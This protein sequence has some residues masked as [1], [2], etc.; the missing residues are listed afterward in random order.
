M[1]KNNRARRAA[2]SRNRSRD[3]ARR[4]GDDTGR[5]SRWAPPPDGQPL[6]G[7]P[8]R[9]RHLLWQAAREQHHSDRKVRGQDTRFITQ[10]A[11]LPATVTAH[12]LED[13]L[14]QC[15]DA[16]WTGG[17]QPAEL[18]R[19][20][21]LGCATAAAARLV[22][23]AM[24]VDHADRAP[25][26]LDRRWATQIDALDLPSVNGR[27]GWVAQWTDD[28]ALDHAAAIAAMVDAI[29]CVGWLPH[30][31]AILAP[32]G[33]A[34]VRSSLRSTTDIGRARESD[35]VLGRIRNLLA[36]A[37]STTFEA[38]AM[39]LT[40]KAQELMTRHAIDAAML[41]RDAGQPSDAPTAIRVPIDAP[42][43]DAKSL[44][45]QTVAEATRCRSVMHAGLAMSTVVGF[46]DDLAAVELLFT[47]LLV[48]AQTALNDAATHAPAGTRTRSQ[49][50]RAAFL[51]AFINRIDERLQEIND[52]V[53]TQVRT[54]QGDAFLPVLRSRAKEVD[55]AFGSRFGAMTTSRVRNSYDP[56]GWAGGTIAADNARLNA[57]DIAEGAA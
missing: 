13:M 3:R 16:T 14:I 35:V 44:L 5:S 26:T 45:L 36:K 53:Y 50:Y 40:A 9:A 38:E 47:S 28:E 15:V 51:L 41:H 33:S 46:V 48:Q 56:A 12:A 29:A 20:A 54:E 32:P 2:K 43:L 7:E 11:R 8:E 55:D 31:D 25:T 39:A 22:A 4:A 49:S 1:G 6:F 23:R 34:D 57:A 24:A 21:R 18:H 30:L 10:L 42:Y 27:S 17:W 19:Q 52:A 37:E